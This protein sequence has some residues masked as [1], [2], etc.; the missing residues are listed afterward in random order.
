MAVFSFRKPWFFWIGC[1]LLLGFIV[2]TASMA[3][4]PEAPG[5]WLI[6]EVGRN[7]FAR[8]EKPDL[9][10]S[11]SFVV[12][13]ETE[14]AKQP[15]ELDRV[16]WGC[17]R[18]IW[19]PR[20]INLEAYAGQKVLLRLKTYT[21]YGFQHRAYFLWGHPRIVAG[22]LTEQD[23]M[24]VLLDLAERYR[25]AEGAWAFVGEPHG[26]KT[27]R[28]PANEKHYADPAACGYKLQPGLSAYPSGRGSSAMPWCI[29]FEITVPEATEAKT[30]AA[31]SP[32]KGVVT[33]AG[34]RLAVLATDNYVYAPFPDGTAGVD[35]NTLRFDLRMPNEDN[36]Q[37]YAFAGLETQNVTS[38]EIKADYDT[39]GPVI[40]YGG[41]EHNSFAGIVLDY[42]TPR[43]YTRRVWLCHPDAMPKS[44]SL[45]S[46]RNVPR[47]NME[48]EVRGRLEDLQWQ[49]QQRFETLPA[50][51]TFRLDLT[52]YAPVDWDGRLWIGAGLQDVGTSKKMSLTITDR[53]AI[54]STG[55]VVE[56]KPVSLED[57]TARFVFSDQTGSLLEGW[58]KKTGRQ[59]LAG[60]FDPYRLDTPIE[61]LRSTEALDVVD[62]MRREEVDGCP[63][64]V[65]ECRNLGL[66]QIRLEK[67][68]TLLPDGE[69]SKRVEFQTD[70]PE[71]FFV[72]WDC[73]SRVPAEFAV[74]AHR[75]GELVPFKVFSKYSS[76]MVSDDYSLGVASYR[77]KVNDRFVLRGMPK[78]NRPKPPADEASWTHIVF[79]DW[80]KQG[81]PVSAETRWHIFHGDAFA[82]DRFY[83][84]HPEYQA[85]WDYER[86]EWTK[87]V[88]ADAMRVMNG[89]EEF[90]ER[91][92]P[93]LVTG[94]IWN[95]YPPWGNWWAKSDPPFYSFI[96]VP[97]YAHHYRTDNPNARVAAYT[98]L[99]VMDTSDMYKDHPEFLIRGKN[100][101]PMN[102]GYLNHGTPAYD[103]QLM[104]P[105]CRQYIIDMHADRT[106]GW[107][108]DFHY[109][110]GPGYGF[111]YAD[112][113]YRD[114]SQEYE[115]RDFMRDLR[116]RLQEV[117]PGCAI[118]VNG[119]QKPY[120]DFGYIEFRSGEW[121]A[122]ASS[123]AEHWRPLARELLA[124]KI[125]NPPE[126]IIV[127]TYGW[128]I[129]DP[130]CA[131]YTVFYG[132]LGNF[133]YVERY[134][135]MEY[136][137]HYREMAVVED[138]VEP[139]WW[140]NP[141]Q[142]FEAVGFTKEGIG[143][144]NVMDHKEAESRTV[145]VTVDT[146]KLGLTPGQPLYGTLR[147][148]T[149]AVPELSGEGRNPKGTYK[150][151]IAY[152]EK[153]FQDWK[154]CPE[155]LELEI[156][157][158][159]AHVSTVLL[160]HEKGKTLAPYM[161]EEGEKTE[162]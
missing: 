114:V 136:A 88:V 91:A 144:V 70:D 14:G 143:I 107:D 93:Y 152:T 51:E 132:W 48:P 121:Q 126:H 66:P 129:A 154:A 52:E 138:A 63:S 75:A 44:P 146:K 80:V 3:K 5:P 157:V 32:K 145:K 1:L 58:D 127:P 34:K 84:S 110:D 150:N 11:G 156:P 82:H 71:G 68:Y 81:A 89:T 2:P 102:N 140:R 61:K 41:A 97:R 53:V 56:T 86:P 57:E 65:F 134:P 78:G 37:G 38:L 20:A 67:R 79:A 161:P 108:L 26:K 99:R 42:H 29:E 94:T 130:A 119:V 106:K 104:R 90:H 6:F 98:N 77:F 151:K 54:G 33:D 92:M 43:G 109:M 128:P 158:N 28:K 87:R 39:Y 153:P 96:G 112:W 49:Q 12:E 59:V 24:P 115:Y 116:T 27:E 133:W 103:I 141:E 85:L 47:W 155:K 105:D 69:L 113:G 60:D 22:P 13:I 18:G 147:L 117:K 118:F 25:K 72:F 100:G 46:E 4:G 35:I 7:Q 45:R 101:L 23:D 17:I 95:I 36:G 16:Q 30:P 131:S 137:M 55:D 31:P 10:Q 64:V 50:S 62:N 125:N 160:S 15:V 122:L 74:Q 19:L 162:E 111:E 40:N 148:M 9:Y 124:I 76:M 159:R 21:M 142:D 73:L 120:T 123:E 8:Q 135:W 139:R 83:M 149:N